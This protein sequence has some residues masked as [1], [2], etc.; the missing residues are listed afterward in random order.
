MSSEP[1]PQ[2]LWH[3]H[4]AP[5]IPLFMCETNS[6]PVPRE[7]SITILASCGPVIER[8]GK[9][10]AG[11]EG[12]KKEKMEEGENA[13]EEEEGENWSRSSWPGETVSSKGS[14]ELW[15]MVV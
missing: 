5:E 12:E 10:G 4:Q 3:V 1:W 11:G 14:H 8:E 15:K 2:V 7:M 6:R 13:E 9:G